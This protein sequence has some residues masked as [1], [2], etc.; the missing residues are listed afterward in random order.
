MTNPNSNSKAETT[1]PEVNH[2]KEQAKAQFESI[3]EMVA[4]LDEETARRAAAEEYAKKIDRDRC[5]ELLTE[6]SI[7]TDDDETVETLREAV[8]ESIAD[9]RCVAIGLIRDR[10]T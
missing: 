1:Q 5:V 4:A 8:I 6:V 9:E 10:K 7:D 2:A 3:I